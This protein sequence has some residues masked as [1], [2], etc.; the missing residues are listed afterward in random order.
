MRE[1]VLDTETT[2][3]DPKDGHRLV[4]IGCIEL[5]NH[6]ATGRSYHQYV[7][8]ERDIPTAA[9]DVHGLSEE[10]LSKHP[11]FDRIADDF[12][13]FIGESPLVIHN[14]AFDM[15]F[16]NAELRRS[17]RSVLPMDRAVD[18]VSMARRRYPGAPASLDALCRRFDIDNSARAKHGALLDAELLAEVY[19]EL[20]GGR[21]PGLG[22]SAAEAGASTSGGG[23]V[24][25]PIRK[26]AVVRPPRP[27]APTADEIAAHEAF[28]ATLKSPLW[29]AGQEPDA[30]G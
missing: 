24:V 20:R 30:A 7:N 5:F 4:E 25:L 8:P 16:I 19:L 2:G 6:I 28:V 23:N 29:H 1:I 17:G 22:L 15:G 26:A 18:T 3:L 27:H 9:Y 13:E 14:S 10:F 11:V 12:L 21:Q